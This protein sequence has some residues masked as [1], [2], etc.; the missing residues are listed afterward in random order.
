MRSL[1]L[2]ILTVLVVLM[3]LPQPL[4]AQALSQQ[5]T[6]LDTTIVQP[7]NSYSIPRRIV[8]LPIFPP[9]S[10]FNVRDADWFRG[11][12]YFS[13]ANNRR[14]GFTDIPFHYVVSSD[15][16]I[17]K[18][19]SGGEE[20]KINI[21]GIG[22]DMV[23]IGYLAGKS[24]NAFDSRASRA[25]QDLLVE[26]ANK[27]A[28]PVDKI[29]VDAVKYVKND[30]EKTISL[31]RQDLFGLWSTSLKE[32]VDAIRPRYSPQ[33]KAYK[34]QLMEV[35]VPTEPVQAGQSSPAS[36][37]VKN[38]GEFGVYAGTP[39]ELF[40]TKQGGGVSKFYLNNSWASTSQI[41]LMDEAEVLLPG[42]EKSFEF[43]LGSTLNFGD[44]SEDFQLHTL[45]GAVIEGTK[46]TIKVNVARPSG[47]IVEVLPSTPG[48]VR[49]RAN[50]YSNAAEVT[51][52]STGERA[53]QIDQNNV[54]WVKLRLLD[55]K[56]GWVARSSIKTI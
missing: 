54:G 9:S 11:I 44:I 47:T 15:G 34:L 35:N 51:R 22:E 29:T 39:A 43:Q 23:V 25:L 6:K 27:N 42:E 49:V 17:F 3:V 50:P 19:N 36:I 14:S 37:K 10:S 26:V 12:Y 1:S 21:K 7:D 30:A 5:Q 18:G 46:F 45:S 2:P 41:Q 52:L 55:G 28:I 53:F 8:V 40:A 31:E 20:R 32:N 13:I 56:E 4:I 16:R 38:V 24:D 33:P 48:F